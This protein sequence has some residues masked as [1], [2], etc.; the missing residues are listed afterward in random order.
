M[1][2]FSKAEPKPKTQH[3]TPVLRWLPTDPVGRRWELWTG[4]GRGLEYVGR[5]LVLGM[6]GEETI[7]AGYFTRRGR[8]SHGRETPQGWT[9]KKVHTM[10]GGARLLVLTFG[11]SKPPLR[12]LRSGGLGSK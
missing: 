2:S 12:G 1:P 8:L 10:R 9:E 11:K 7:T 3:P 5:V 6:K 4:E